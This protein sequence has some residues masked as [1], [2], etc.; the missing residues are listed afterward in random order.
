MLTDLKYWLA[1]NQ[2]T[3]IGPNRFKKLYNYFPTMQQAWQASNLELQKAGIEPNIAQ[4]FIIKKNQINPDQE[5]DKLQ[6][7]NIQVITIK[8][9]AYPKLLKE[10]FYPPA[11]LYIKGNLANLN[12]HYNIAVVG[13][14]KI[15][16][17]GQQITPEI[18]APL[19]KNG[20][21]I[22]SGLALG[23]DALAHQTTLQTKGK[24]IAILG[25]GIDKQSI[26]PSSNRYLANSIL[27]NQ[28][29]IISEFPIATM[30]LKQNFPARNRIIAGLTLGTIVL[31]AGQ[32]SGALITAYLAL[33]NNREVFAVP[34]PLTSP[35][36][37]GTHKLIQQGAKLITGYEDILQELNLPEQTLF[38]NDPKILP[39]NKEQELI[40]ANLNLQPTHIDQL[41]KNTNL[42]PQIINS[43]LSLME[44]NGMIKN[45]GSQ[46]YIIL[47]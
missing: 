6:Q 12:H 10:I 39:E 42:P 28:G 19:V 11:L 34:G 40:L 27:Q 30:P 29:T 16:A 18:V 46:N 31:E 33:E 9:E 20:F 35:T 45:L 36:S 17:Y 5:L 7:E 21:I 22:T 44:M 37:I 26:Y 13:T 15:S 38:K 4:E 25:S 14:R 2:F 43:Q 1:I 23:I 41:I 32:R 3:K 47:N 24:T 8:D